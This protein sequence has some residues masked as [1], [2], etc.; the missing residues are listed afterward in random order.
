[1]GPAQFGPAGWWRASRLFLDGVELGDP[2]DGWGR[3]ASL[4]D[5]CKINGVEPFAWLSAT[6]TVIAAGHPKSRI[7]D[8]LSWNFKPST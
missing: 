4:I 8:L 3:I 2:G 5:T 7:D 6:L 1:M